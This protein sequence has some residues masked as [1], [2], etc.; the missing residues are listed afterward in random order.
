M[1]LWDV[2]TQNDFMLP[3]EKLCVPDAEQAA[4]TMKRLV[5]AAR[6]AHARFRRPSRRIRRRSHWSHC[7]TVTSPEASSSC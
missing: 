7:Q 5:E 3:D 6:A 4:A 2:D 1:I